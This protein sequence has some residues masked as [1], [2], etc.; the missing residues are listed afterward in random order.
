MK[1][2]ILATCL[3]F[4]LCGRGSAQQQDSLVIELYTEAYTVF[5][6]LQPELRQRPAY[7]C[8]YTRANQPGIN[9]ALARLH[10][11]SDH[12]RTS[13]GVMAGDYSRAN[14][15]QEANW[16]RPIYEAYVGYRFTKK[17]NIWMDAGVFPSHIGMETAIGKE[18]RTATRSLVADNS[19]YYETGL[20]LS[21]RHN[22]YWFFSMVAL[23]GWQRIT[24]PFNQ[25][26][27]NWGMQITYTPRSGVTLNSSS[28]IGKV[29][30]AP[31]TRYLSRI[32]S[33]LW[34]VLP[35][36]ER[37]Q[38]ALGWDIGLQ[39]TAPG[40]AGTAIWNHLQAGVTHRLHPEKWTASLRYEQMIDRKNV[41]HV[42][43][44]NNLV[45]FQVQQATFNVDYRPLASVLLR[46][47]AGWLHS[48]YVVYVD[49]NQVQ[50][51]LFTASLLLA[52]HF[53]H[54]R[55]HP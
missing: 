16:A 42:P 21:Y 29:Q 4:L 25:L 19:P 12:F 8:S 17:E 9:L 23:N 11:S 46:A 28:F 52:W 32:Y 13:V 27:T 45:P 35:V 22:R 47:E 40:T 51:N 37:T 7:F 30:E 18:N 24:A 41:L 31:G 54:T 14:L 15:A 6:P 26:G 2:G 43:A 34:G 33:N 10:Y 50:K 5:T 55:V 20:R 1:Q 3:L 53:R 38:M 48:P 39:E 49:G 36:S 44:L